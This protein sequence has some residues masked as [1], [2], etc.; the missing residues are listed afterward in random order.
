M[1]AVEV[2]A[3]AWIANIDEGVE[4]RA[5]GALSSSMERKSALLIMDRSAFRAWAL[6][7]VN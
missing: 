6:S 3:R 7:L 4:S 1:G 5:L 2:K